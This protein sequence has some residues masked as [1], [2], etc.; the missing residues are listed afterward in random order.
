MDSVQGKSKCPSCLSK[1]EPVRSE[2]NGRLY[3]FECGKVI[4]RVFLGVP[5]YQL[6]KIG[7]VGTIRLS[8][9]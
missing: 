1:A 6:V 9:N 3:C 5:V 4:P 2:V 7:A 8:L